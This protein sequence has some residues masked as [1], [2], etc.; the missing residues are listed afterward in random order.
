MRFQIFLVLLAA[1]CLLVGVPAAEE[2]QTGSLIIS[3]EKP[4]HFTASDGT[5]IVAAP[6]TYRVEQAEG[7]KLK[8]V[9]V[10]EGASTRSAIT[11]QAVAA[12]HEEAVS[13]PLALSFSEGQDEHHVVLLLSDGKGLDAQGTYSGVRSRA[14]R[15]PIS[16]AVI[17]QQ[18]VLKP[19][20]ATLTQLHLPDMV[21]VDVTGVPDAITSLDAN[22]E[23]PFFYAT[24]LVENAG[25]AAAW[26][27]SNNPWVS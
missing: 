5:D 16:S 14:I 4:V 3:L 24:L 13:V 10:G 23:C 18:V 21:I 1:L 8:L 26:V 20:Y 25:T 7:T 11:V 12:Q 22:G 27:P 2:T 6:G 9:P 19:S 17:R 15:R